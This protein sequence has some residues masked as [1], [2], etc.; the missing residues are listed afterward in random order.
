MLFK[1]SRYVNTPAAIRDGNLVFT[2]RRRVRFDLSLALLYR[3][4]T[5]D[6]LDLLARKY[7]GDPSKWWAILEANP[8]YRSEFEINAGEVIYIPSRAEVEGA[9]R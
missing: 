7:Y 9:I 4:S 6:R 2:R 5:Y 3:W 8:S 1:G